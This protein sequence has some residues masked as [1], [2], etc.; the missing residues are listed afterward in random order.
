MALMEIEKPKFA[1]WKFPAPIKWYPA[2]S[3]IKFELNEVAFPTW[4]DETAGFVEA[5]EPK[6]IVDFKTLVWDVPARTSGPLTGG[7]LVNRFMAVL[8]EV[9][10]EAGEEHHYTPKTH[11]TGGGLTAL[12]VHEGQGDCLVGRVLIRMGQTPEDLHRFENVGAREVIRNLYPGHPET[13]GLA[14]VAQTAQMVNDGMAPWGKA[15]TYCEEQ[16]RVLA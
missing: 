9:V 12:Y 2:P 13:L 6:P 4:K 8:R 10:T 16:V 1:G 7:P 3:D 5:G 15:V 11:A 14:E